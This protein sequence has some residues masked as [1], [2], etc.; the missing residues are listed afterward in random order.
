MMQND[1]TYPEVRETENDTEK[2][3]IHFLNA[4][5]PAYYGDI[6]RALKLSYKKGQEHLTSLQSKGL[7]RQTKKPLKIEVNQ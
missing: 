2:K 4:H 5:G 3:I 1:P 6:L 7:I